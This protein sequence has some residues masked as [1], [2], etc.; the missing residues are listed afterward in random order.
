MS[1][2]TF[3]SF[4]FNIG[5]YIVYYPIAITIDSDSRSNAILSIIT[6]FSF[7]FNVSFYIVYYPIAIII[8]RD[9]RGNAII[10]LC[11]NGSFLITYIPIAIVVNVW[12]RSILSISS[13]F[14]LQTSKAYRGSPTF[15]SFRS[16]EIYIAEVYIIISYTTYSSSRSCN[17]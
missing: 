2:I 1:I 11:F 9:S 4:S 6:F 7:S 13:L 5:F 16:V 14:S 10:P 8:N 17:P 15:G 12:Y 3:F